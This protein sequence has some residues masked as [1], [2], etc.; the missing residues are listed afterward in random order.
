MSRDGGYGVAKQSKHREY[1]AGWLQK[2]TDNLC[3]QMNDALGQPRDADEEL[4]RHHR[5]GEAATAFFEWA[6]HQVWHGL[7]PD[8]RDQQYPEWRERT[9]AKLN[10]VVERAFAKA[11]D[12]AGRRRRSQSD[13]AGDAG[14]EDR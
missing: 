10:E 4:A 1:D 2:M 13:D 12:D 14:T 5:A 6:N 11:R 7:M 9:D 3:V 8:Q